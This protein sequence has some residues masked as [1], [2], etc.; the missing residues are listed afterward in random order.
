MVASVTDL[1]GRL[2]GTHRTRLD[3]R[4]F[5]EAPL[6]K[7][8][9]ATPGRAMDALRGYPVRFGV[10]GEMMAARRRHRDQAYA[11]YRAHGRSALG[12]ASQGTQR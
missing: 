8:P 6:G 7:A 10:V 9:I 3:P 11:A 12:G 1:S 5:S 2:T 4:G